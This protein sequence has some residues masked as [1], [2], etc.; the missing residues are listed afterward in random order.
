VKR[1][2]GKELSAVKSSPDAFSGAS[3]GGRGEDCASAKAVSETVHAPLIILNSDLRV[4]S[5]NK[6]FYN[7]FQAKREETENFLFHDLEDGRW[8]IP[9]LRKLLKNVLAGGRPFEGFQADHEIP[10][11]GSRTLSLN[12]RR[13]SGGEEN[14]PLILL[15][16]VDITERRM[17]E[18]ALKDR[19]SKFR[20]SAALSPVGIF[21]A[22]AAGEYV[23]TNERWQEIAGISFEQ[24][25]G[26]G[27]SKAIHS[28]DRRRVLDEWHK[29]IRDNSSFNLEFRFQRPD[30]VTTWVKGQTL[31]ER[32]DTGGT[33]GYVGTITDIT[34]LKETEEALREFER[35][36]SYIEVTGQLGWTTNPDGGG[37]RSLPGESIPAKRMMRLKVG[38]GRM[39]CTPMTLSIHPGYGEKP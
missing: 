18:N 25:L 35:Y 37:G 24:A 10:G 29:S 31:S 20:L 19:E 39:L 9:E 22:N 34:R 26:E 38:D 6:S 4:L 36:R 16:M 2:G 7:T 5:A 33:A 32:N 1:K 30:G 23:F 13:I 11:K 17:L 21:F 3:A 14:G 28:E 15:T 12:A 27:W 8:N